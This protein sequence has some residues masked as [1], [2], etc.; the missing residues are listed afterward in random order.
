MI[1]LEREDFA[2]GR[3]EVLAKTAGMSVSGFIK[4]FSPLTA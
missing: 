2:R 1:R 4:R 3:V